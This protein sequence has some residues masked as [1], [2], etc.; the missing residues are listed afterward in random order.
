M[1][2]RSALRHDFDVCDACITKPDAAACGPY[3]RIGE[4][5]D[6]GACVWGAGAALG[7]CMCIDWMSVVCSFGYVGA[8]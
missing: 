4:W 7:M 3:E 5:A 1:R 8:G 6:P 2:H